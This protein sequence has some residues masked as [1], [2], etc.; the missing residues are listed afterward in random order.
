MAHHHNG[1]NYYGQSNNSQP[2]PPP[3][4]YGGSYMRRAPSFDSG[5]DVSSLDAANGNVGGQTGTRGYGA[6]RSGSNAGRQEDELFMGMPSPPITQPARTSSLGPA[7]SGYQ[8]Q[9]EPQSPPATQSTYNPQQFASSQSQYRS[10]AYNNGNSNYGVSHHPYVPAAYQNPNV[11]RQSSISGQ[12]YGYAPYTSSGLANYTPPTPPLP[13]SAAQQ[14]GR[15]SSQYGGRPISQLVNLQPQRNTPYSPGLPQQPGSA[16]LPPRP[17]AY[18]PPAPPP[19][20]FPPSSGRSSYVDAQASYPHSSPSPPN[21]NSSPSLSEYQ[22]NRDPYSFVSRVRRSSQSLQHSPSNA[23]PPL[24]GPRPPQHSPDQANSLRRHPTLRPL[25]GTPRNV[26]TGSDGLEGLNGGFE[27][28]DRTAEQI[29]QEDIWKEVE[30]AVMST[31][32]PSGSHARRSRV[33]VD[34]ESPIHQEEEPQPSFTSGGHGSD[35]EQDLCTNGHADAAA[36]GQHSDYE[37]YGDDSDAEAAAGLEAMR[38]A[39]EQEAADVGP[40]FGSYRAQHTEQQSPADLSSDSDYANID[41]GLYGGGYEG[42]MSYGGQPL[43]QGNFRQPNHSF[44]PLPIPGAERNPFSIPH[45]DEIHPFPSFG[46]NARVDTDGTGGLSEPSPHKR[47]LS[48]DE[49][50][51][52]TLVG[53]EAGQASGDQ[54]PM[55]DDLPDLFYHPGMSSNSQ[56]PLPQAP[57]GS[58]ADNRVPQL[59]AAGAYQTDARYD[60]YDQRPSYP[61]AP[62]AYAQAMLTP[63][64][65]IV[66]RSSS[67]VSHSSTPQMVPPIRSKTDAEERRAK[68]LKQ[69]QLGLRSAVL[70]SD[71][72]YDTSTPQSSVTLDLPAIP[73]GKRKKFH[74]AKLSTADFKKCAEPWALSAIAGW[75]KEMSEGEADLRK[76]L[77]IDGIV[78]LFTHKVP[79]MNT[80][81]AETL[82]ARVVEEMFSAGTLVHEEEWVKFGTD[83]I[84]GVIW[85]LTGSGCYA[86]RLH[87][88]TMAGRC[89]AHHCSRTLKKINLQ[90]QVLEPQRK[91][92]DWATFHKLKKE[93]LEGRNKK[94]V[95]RQNILHEIVQTEDGYMDQLN[96]LRI[97]Y[98]DQLSSWQPPIITPKRIESFLMEVFGKVDAVKKVNE[99]YLLAQLKYRQQEQGPWV[100]GFSDIF[101]EWIRKAKNAYIE[102]AAYFPN[103]T[104]L[105]RKESERNIL[106][107]QFLDQA[108]DNERSKRLGW[109]TYLKAPI[110]RLQRYGLL[111]FTV[112]KNMLQD[113]E[114]KTNLQIAIDEIK[115]VTLDCDAKVAE[116]S[117]KVDLSELGSKLVLR[118]GMERVELNLNH[119]GRELIFKGDLQRTGANRFTWLETHAILFDHYLVLAK[120]VSQRDAAGGL[121][122]ER[123]DVSKLPIPMDL[124]VLESTNDDPV[125]KSSVRGIG[126]VTTVTSRAQPSQDVRLGRTT[127]N[128]QNGPGPGTLA[129]SNT[130][131]SITS[132]STTASGKTINANT[133]LDG[134]KD[135]KVMFPFRV[136]HLG[137]SEVYTLYAPS[138]QNRQDWCDKI[139]EAKTKHAAALFAQNAEPFRLR[140]VADTAFGYEALAGSPRSIIIRG[141]PLD[142]A[143]REV[144]STYE[145]AGP[146]PGPVCRAAVYC[147]TAFTQ[148]YGKQMVAIGTDYGVYISEISNPRGWTRAIQITRV[149]QIAVLEEFSLFL[150]IADKSLIAYHLDVVCPVSGMPPTNDSARRAPQKLSGAKDV[151]FFATGRMKER[152]LVFYKK[153]ESLSSTFKV[154]EPIF[155]KSTEKKS[156]FSRKGVT[157]FFREYDEFYIP[158]ECFGINLYNSSLAVSTSRGFEVLTLDK[159]QPWSVPDLKQT[160][161]AATASRLS[162]QRPLGMFRLSDTEFLLCYEECA[163]Y[164]N[165]HGDVSRS[166]IM[167][168]VGKAKSA[169]LYGPYILLFDADF[170]EIRNAQNGRLR[171]VIAG[172]D[173]RCLDDGQSGGSAGQRTVKISLQ[174]PEMERTQ[175]VVELVLNEGQKE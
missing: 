63:L 41:M 85:Q 28:E 8:H 103:A 57:V 159:K 40:M 171:Q 49:G 15:T 161:V 9:Y 62:D 123:Y 64:G 54:S 137:K 22:N 136:K 6:Y 78:A 34:E 51:E 80:A 120:T 125:V 112:H 108:R 124:L 48:F 164:V 39:E 144:E 56:R 23:L 77:I 158:T 50:D 152:T 70:D 86:P 128:Q 135:E 155:Q 173:V 156:R 115:A 132:V 99:D 72:G 153:R 110:T 147:A 157:E 32:S 93:D 44:R 130:N 113:T 36:T 58:E 81:D 148:P 12:S 11:Q 30:A 109:D 20:P 13:Q 106:F 3:G 76:H 25:P 94:E 169:A 84:S 139:I 45:Q 75:V 127:S 31:G 26:D 163:V 91:L 104:F 175:I 160:H 150:V 140:V 131:S 37:S 82:G 65:S 138:D 67:L 129:H 107:R 97:L 98:R 126:A 21:H 53:S 16:P 52:V 4:S 68:L 116:M 69:Q 151:G 17:T 83:S 59:M 145:H 95:E 61:P 88:Q 79:T 141:T 5:D 24:P 96:V 29:A 7:L 38:M 133:V 14:F 105:V 89:Y 33:E 168:F 71:I 172:R 165:K 111:L 27:E 100:V 117:K 102:Y 146:K 162:G 114:E 174:H 43:P 55:R 101:R 42:H 149:T 66:P 122:Y 167:E 2:P 18:S 46:A 60:S 47:R 73:V 19:P 170:V 119:L 143:I 92:E 154:L 118:P 166:V 134:P 121:K 87:T 10:P 35:S 142:R 74:P 1:Q 90:T